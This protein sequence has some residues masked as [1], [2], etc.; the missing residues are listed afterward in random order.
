MQQSR[1]HPCPPPPF[2]T[3]LNP[4]AFLRSN[5]QDMSYKQPLLYCKRHGIPSIHT[6]DPFVFLESH[7]F[8]LPKHSLS[9]SS[10]PHLCF[11]TKCSP[12]PSYCLLCTIKKI[13]K[14]GMQSLSN[15]TTLKIPKLAKKLFKKCSSR[16]FPFYFALQRTLPN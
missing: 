13:P 12:H 2:L 4:R 9:I 10:Y 6:N 16:A 7:E 1:G 8:F 11:F 15:F 3:N 14:K 5:P